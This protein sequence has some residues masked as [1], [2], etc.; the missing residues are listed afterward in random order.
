L[1]G[2]A[3]TL[4]AKGA[5]LLIRFDSVT[6]LLN[7]GTMFLRFPDFSSKSAWPRRTSPAPTLQGGTPFRSNPAS[8]LV[9]KLNEP[10][11]CQLAI[12]VL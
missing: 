5:C 10:M 11:N 7:F 8:P 4:Q 12:A 9:D 1:G 2:A 3:R 6:V